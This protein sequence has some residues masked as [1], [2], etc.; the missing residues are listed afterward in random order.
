MFK[1]I[2]LKNRITSLKFI[3]Q[4]FQSFST[5]DFQF[6]EKRKVNEK[7]ERGGNPIFKEEI[8]EGYVDPFKAVFY[9]KKQKNKK[10]ELL[11]KE[12][13]T[14]PE[15]FNA[16]PHL[17]DKAFPNK[18][19]D[20]SILNNDSQVMLNLDTKKSSYFESLKRNYENFE[21]KTEEEKVRENEAN[22]VDAYSRREGPKKYMSREEK[23]KIHNLIDE[24][25]RELENTG[26]SREEILLNKPV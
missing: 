2:S 6:G 3:Q 16:F 25:M 11:K 7:E 4:R 12:M 10:R 18:E 8:K 17:R 24:K 19:D 21:S 14:N 22:F 23:E 15:F 1:L 26:L 20:Q 13:T 9:S 5:E